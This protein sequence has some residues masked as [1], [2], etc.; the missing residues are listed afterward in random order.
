[1]AACKLEMMCIT[2]YTQDGNGVISDTPMFSG[3]SYPMELVVTP[4]TG[5]PEVENPRWQSTLILL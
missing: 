2:A 4:L 1:M 3:S 5:K